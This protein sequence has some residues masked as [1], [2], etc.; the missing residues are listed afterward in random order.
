MFGFSI[1]ASVDVQI[2]PLSF[3]IFSAEKLINPL[4]V[5]FD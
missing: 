1:D 5:V 2:N 4:Q 3:W